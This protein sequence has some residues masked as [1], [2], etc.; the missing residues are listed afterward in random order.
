MLKDLKYNLPDGYDERQFIRKLADYYT[1]EK[2]PAI[3]ER[4]GFFDTFDWR[5]F[6]KSLV[7]YGAGN[8]LLLR[9]LAKSEIVHT[10]EIGSL[11]VFIWDF[12]EGKLKKRLAPIIKM[13]ALLKLVDLYSQSTT[14]RILN[15]DE[16]TVVRF[17]YEEI[18]LSRDKSGPSLA[19]HLWLK[20]IKGYPKY[21]RNLAKQF[22]EAGLIIPK[23]ED[24]YLKALEVVDK[25]PGS[26]T[27]KINI[28]LDPGMHSNEATKNILRLLLQ[29]I[30]INEAYI[31]KDL[32]TEFVHEFRVAIRKTRSALGQIQCV[33]PAKTTERFKK[34][35]A[36][37]GK[38]S[39]DLR[40]LDVYLLNENIY[41][42]MLPPVLRDDI[43]PLFDYLRKKRSSAFQQ[44][45][46]G[47]K[48]KKY[49]KILKDWEVFLNQSQQDDGTAPNAELPIVDLACM[50]IYKKYRRVVKAGNLILEN[51]EDE[52]LH[53][54][55]IHCK[56]LRYL[57]EF[58]S[59]LFDRKKINVLIVQLK[60]LQDNLGDFNDLCVQ[61]EY[62]LN[63]TK[64]MPATQRQLKE[65]LVAIGSLIG[66]L[67]RERQ[68]VKDAFAETF[69]DFSSRANK[70]LF[71]ELFTS[72]I[73]PGHAGTKKDKVSRK[74]KSTKTRK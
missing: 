52:M 71:K 41:K 3:A 51:A 72:Q 9:K 21:S 62:L 19:T 46:G 24:I 2:E 27:A 44:V 64:E 8:K 6:N 1:L 63:I 42:A 11:P 35:F 67:D 57:M 22:E 43:D 54:L 33:F 10:I 50:R 58:F 12:P 13:R 34:D 55:R 66:T 65:T 16:K 69:T 37:V 20:P 60:K 5:L 29:V 38:L 28:K 26:Y 70:E 59:S 15:R 45:I 18:R 14:Y 17:A 36:F 74:L 53:A 40:D 23:K 30:R 39:N 68:I 48:S 31:D 61:E 73:Q 56:K 32:D 47:L 25:T 7:L 4:I 49:G